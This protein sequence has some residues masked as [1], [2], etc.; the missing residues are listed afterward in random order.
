MTYSVPFC[1]V[2]FDDLGR[3]VRHVSFCVVLCYKLGSKMVA[4]RSGLR[5]M[6]IRQQL[7][8]PLKPGAGKL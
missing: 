4:R 8:E 5:S 3:A 6:I 7:I 2:L 1:F